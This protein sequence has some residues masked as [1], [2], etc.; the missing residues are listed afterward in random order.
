[1][2]KTSRSARADEGSVMLNLLEAVDRQNNIT[3]RSLA[4]ELGVAVGLINAYV[5]RSVKRGLIKVQQVPKRRFAYYLTPQGFAEKSRLAAL[6]LSSS[7]EF[8]RKARQD[9]EAVT[10][11]ACK[12]GWHR[13][14]LVGASDLAE[15]A[16]VCAP[17]VKARIVGVVDASM[18]RARFH[19]LPVWTRLEEAREAA[20]AAM[21]TSLDDA[22]AA[23]VGA[24]AVFGADRVLVPALLR[25]AV[26][27]PTG[28]KEG[29]P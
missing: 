16:I 23:Y 27:G 24:A 20:D 4:D 11:M 1:M 7:F 28:K 5:K 8:F 14:A 6:Y 17:D 29:A 2:T 19:G 25:P 26:A 18:G 10:M 21:V 9:C 22:R 12:R 13:V 15:I 3:Q